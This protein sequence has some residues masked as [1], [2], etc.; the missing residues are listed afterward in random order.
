MDTCRL[1]VE[2]GSVRPHLVPV[3][4]RCFC[5][6]DKYM[7]VQVASQYGSSQ[8]GRPWSRHSA[9]VALCCSASSTSC[10]AICNACSYYLLSCP[11]P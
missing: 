7:P 1:T 2:V 4:G 11:T 5:L 6:T 10:R 8:L 3:A 9:G